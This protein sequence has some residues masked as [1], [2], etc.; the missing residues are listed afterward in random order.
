MDITRAHARKTA[1][2][3]HFFLAISSLEPK[4]PLPASS[5]APP[6]ATQ[7]TARRDIPRLVTPVSTQV[8]NFQHFFLR[9]WL[10]FTIFGVYLQSLRVRITRARA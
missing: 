4:I 2:F 9:K 7:A 3:F 1:I 10:I 5:S 8:V 6:A